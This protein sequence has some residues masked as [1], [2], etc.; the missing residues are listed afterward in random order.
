M[1]RATKSPRGGGLFDPN[2]MRRGLFFVAVGTV[3][4][5]LNTGGTEPVDTVTVQKASPRAELFFR[6][7][8][9][10]ARFGKRQDAIADGGDDLGLAAHDPAAGLRG[11]QLIK[12][13]LPLS[14]ENDF[15]LV[16]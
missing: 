2:G 7:V 14:H 1:I 16:A 9:A 8:V 6:E 13:T 3:T 5:F 11:G 15:D 4:V 10:F 12:L